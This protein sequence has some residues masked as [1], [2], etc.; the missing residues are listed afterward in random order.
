MVEAPVLRPVLE[1]ARR[2]LLAIRR[3][4]PLAEPAGHVPV[5]LE[6]ARH[7]G[8]AL[9]DRA[10]VAGERPGELRHRA[11]P[12]TVLVAPRERRRP[13]RRAERDDVEAVVVEAHLPDTRQVR[14]RDRPTERVRL[15][16][17]GVVD[18]DQQH[19]RRPLRSL[20]PRDDRPIGHGLV[21][22]ATHRAAEVPVR[23]RQHGAVGN[24]LPHR[25]RET[26][27]ERLQ[28]L[29]V[30]LDDRLRKRPRQRLL[31]RQPLRLVERR[32][33]R[34]RPGRQMLTDLVVHLR[35]DPMV[36]EP[37]EQAARD[38]TRG[39]GREQRRRG[40]ADEDAH[41]TAPLDPL[42]TAMV[43][44]LRH[45]HRAVLGMRDQDRSLHL[46]P[47]WPRRASRARRS[48]F[49]AASIPGYA[50]TRT[51]VVLSAIT[52]SFQR[53][54]VSASIRVVAARGH[55]PVCTSIRP[56]SAAA[57]SAAKSRSF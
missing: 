36:D 44:R 20:R 30:G 3:H 39:R 57:F 1:R 49:A 34:G 50:P 15:P 42:A 53:F 38:S 28:P 31:D 8:A 9:R 12:D 46:R 33:D 32:E 19:V 23:D 29:L 26:V 24:E 17:P 47:S 56:E 2:A 25:L 48:P 16:E 21:D 41:R 54:L 7:G 6:D 18:Q 5:L 27:L 37:P 14:R 11:H 43:G 52:C 55:G 35:L 10:R 22:R 40:Q 13:R 4:V 51:S 45:V